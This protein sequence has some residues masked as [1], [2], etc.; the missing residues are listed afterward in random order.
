VPSSAV[1]NYRLSA[2]HKGPVAPQG[3]CY[4]RGHRLETAVPNQEPNVRQAKSGIGDEAHVKRQIL[5][6]VIFSVCLGSAGC[7]GSRRQSLEANSCATATSLTQYDAMLSQYLDDATVHPP[8][9]YGGQVVWNSRYYLESL[10]TAYNATQNPKYLNSF[11]DSGTA[12]LNLAQPMNFVD[13]PDATAPGKSSAGPTITRTG[14]PTYMSTFGVPVTIPTATGKDAIYVQGLYP[15]SVL[16][17]VFL[18]I[19]QTPGGLQIA[20]S[21]DGVTFPSYQIKTVEDLKALESVPLVYGQ[22][23]GRIKV[24]GSGL[25]S[26]GDWEIDQPLLT[27]WH[28]E[29]TGGILLPFLKFLLLAKDRPN[30][31]DAKTVS[32]WT[33]KVKAIADDYKDEQFVPDGSGGLLIRNPQWMAST[34]AVLYAEADYTYVEAT[35]RLLLYE[36]VHDPHDLVIAKKLITHQKHFHWQLDANGWLLLKDWPCVQTWSGPGNAPAGSIWSSLSEDPNIPE[37]T[38]AGRFFGDLLQVARQYNLSDNVGLDASVYAAHRKTFREYIQVQ[39]TAGVLIRAFYPI[40]LA[41]PADTIGS[42]ADVLAGAGFLQPAV[43]DDVFVSNQW[44]W[45]LSQ[46]QS[47]RTEP[48]GYF[49]DAWARSE[50]AKL[51]FCKAAAK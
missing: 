24:S 25:P 7:G 44:N 19:T 20:W 3:K 5:K 35:M 47:P 39:N 22:T 46:A 4:P 43:T 23:P 15:A 31:V 34:D 18:D 21:R 17:A 12:V 11:L 37:S 28:G 50:A 42:T 16:G 6:V 49:L 2:H 30:L 41:T 26:V 32:T 38:S 13:G 48:V 51:A 9:N 14:W 1:L 33:A 40:P 29:Q 8:S 36:L 45:M 10:V 27:I